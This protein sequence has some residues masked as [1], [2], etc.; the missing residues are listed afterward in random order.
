M[1][2]GEL[3]ESDRQGE[4]QKL[5]ALKH[6]SEEALAEVLSTHHDTIRS[7]VS[8]PKWHFSPHTRDDVEQSI[9][10]SLMKSLVS[11]NKAA[12]IRAFIKRVSINRCID[13]VRRQVR[14]RGLF[15]PMPSLQTSDGSELVMQFGDPTAPDAIDLITREEQLAELRQKL[16]LLNETCQHA[17]Q[18]FYLEGLSYKEIA[19]AN[20]LAINT[21]GSRLAKCLSKLRTMVFSA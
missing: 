10:H 16:K 20:K 19:A 9:Q 2:D 6:G 12:S 5:S 1:R 21:V 4:I 7:V 11:A 14:E 3:A 18:Q 15:A 13:E 8:W 17:I